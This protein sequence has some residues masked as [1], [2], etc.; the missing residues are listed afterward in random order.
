MKM[1]MIITSEGKD[2]SNN[3]PTPLTLARIFEE[4]SAHSLPQP[5]LAPS[6]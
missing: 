1:I 6:P 2:N 3:N 5:Q 4:D